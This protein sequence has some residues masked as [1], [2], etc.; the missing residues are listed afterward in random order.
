[1]ACDSS[2][3]ITKFYPLFLG[4]FKTSAGIPFKVVNLTLNRTAVIEETIA[5]G[6]WEK[7]KL[8]KF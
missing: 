8:K 5:I 1:M 3:Y 7:N 4:P 2:N 6:L